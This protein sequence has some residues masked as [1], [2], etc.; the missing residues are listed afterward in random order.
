MTPRERVLASL[1]HREPDRV[2]VD[3][4]GHRSSGIMAIAYARLKQ[5]LGITSGDV[6][7]YDVIQQLAI[8]EEPV[9]DALGIDVVEMGRGFL[10]EPKDW[11]AQVRLTEII[12]KYL[13]DP[14]REAE[15][16]SRLLKIEG[17]PEVLWVQSV[18]DLGDYWERQQR[19]DRAKG[20]YKGLIW[21]YPEGVDSG[22]ARRRIKKLEAPDSS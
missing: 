20:I 2:A 16:R 1:D 7:V 3:F 14:E 15:E 5:A 19:P 22:E 12:M 10:L 8:V 17:V 13:N 6:Y 21:K 4:G 11:K 9:L 18:F